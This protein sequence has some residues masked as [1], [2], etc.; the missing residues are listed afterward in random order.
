M[1][2]IDDE[3]LV[4]TTTQSP[5]AAPLPT[6]VDEDVG[7]VFVN[8]SLARAI[9]SPVTFEVVL[10]DGV[11]GFS[12][13]GQD[14]T[15]GEDVATLQ[16]TT[17]TI[18]PGETSGS[19]AI[20]IV[21]DAIAEIEEGFTVTLNSLTNAVFEIC[22]PS[23]LTCTPKQESFYFYISE[24]DKPTVS[25][26]NTDFSVVEASGGTH[27]ETDLRLSAIAPNNV[28]FDFELIDGTAKR[29]T[30]YTPIAS[31]GGI[32]KNSRNL[33]SGALRIPISYNSNYTG[34]KTFSIRVKHRVGSTYTVNFPS[35]YSE[36]VNGELVYT[37]TITIV[38]REAPEIRITSNATDV[39]DNAT[40]F[41]IAEN[42]DRGNLV[43]A[44]QLLNFGTTTPATA[45]QPVSFEYR[46]TDVTT[47]KNSDYMESNNRTETVQIGS[48]I[49]RLMI[50]ITDDIENEG[51]ETFILEFFNIVNGSKFTGQSITYKQTISIIDN[52]LPTLSI[53]NTE[54]SVVENIG[55]GG[56]VVQVML[57][58]STADQ[59]P[60]T[61]GDITFNYTLSD[62]TA[63]VD[64]D[65]TLPEP[66]ARSFTIAEGDLTASFAIPILDDAANP[67]S[68]GSE[69]FDIT[70]NITKGARFGN[71]RI[72]RTRTITIHDNE[73]PTLTFQT[74]PISAI[75][76]NEDAVISVGV[77]LSV[78]HHQDV[79]FQYDMTDITTTKGIDYI[80]DG[81][82][83]GTV[84][85][86][87]K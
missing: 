75:E 47:T 65:Y 76:N 44:Y 14:A 87:N 48:S 8:Y 79:T 73:L 24:N 17:I 15:I 28:V 66:S 30:D 45:A 71:N 11:A 21:D 16:N 58:G 60:A 39:S 42:I 23:L 20:T 37:R 41:T 82:R 10:T 36:M 40:E 81:T 64:S 12:H 53:T 4:V 57:S 6:V 84:S 25:F 49:G 56:F 51:N 61:D 78:S 59:N 31:F 74:E 5:S 55:A 35:E 38:D 3:S 7:N 72:T 46:L 70:I 43:I 19:V 22:N 62:G 13:A 83:I 34:N 85:K 52:E 80:E 2:I 9:S 68:E 54:L 69:T 63:T 1:T 26:T 27:F 50:P 67:M 33:V 32:A 29:N 77:K 86:G 18:P